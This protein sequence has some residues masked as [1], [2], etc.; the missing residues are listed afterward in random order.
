MYRSLKHAG[1]GLCGDCH[2]QLP[3]NASA[4]PT[5]LLVS[6]MAQHHCRCA[7]V[8]MLQ[9]RFHW[10]WYMW[11]GFGSMLGQVHG[12]ASPRSQPG[13]PH[14]SPL[15]IPGGA[16]EGGPPRRLG[17]SSDGR[18][19]GRVAGSSEICCSAAQPCWQAARAGESKLCLP[20][21]P[22]LCPDACAIVPMLLTH[23]QISVQWLLLNY[24]HVYVIIAQ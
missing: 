13:S 2:T 14:C 18:P 23:V 1:A 21:A 8:L 22:A 6:H 19:A 4:Q 3:W 5:P 20:S 9:Y 17:L 24:M 10:M 11:T 7:A 16:P 12:P 15:H